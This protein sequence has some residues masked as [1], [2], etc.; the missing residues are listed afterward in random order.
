[1]SIVVL[2]EVLDSS[3]SKGT[4]RL[5]LVVLAEQAHEDGICWPGVDRLA[6]RVNTTPR[7]IQMLTRELEQ[8]GELLVEHSAGRGNT[9][10]YRVLPPTTLNRLLAELTVRLEKVKSS[11]EKVKDS[12]L[13]LELEKVKDRAEKAN[14]SSPFSDSEKVKDSAEKV[15]DSAQ[16]VKDSVK[17]V[18][19]AS[20]EPTRTLKNLQEPT[21]RQDKTASEEIEV[22]SSP[23]GGLEIFEPEVEGEKTHG[24]DRAEAAGAAG[25]EVPNPSQVK[26]QPPAGG[27]GEATGLEEVPAAGAGGAALAA[28]T[29][30]LAGMRLSVPDLI[31]EYPF[32]TLWTE[33]SPTR[34]RELTAEKQLEHGKRNYRGALIDA[35]D[36]EVRALHAQRKQTH[37]AQASPEPIPDDEIDMDALIRSAPLNGYGHRRKP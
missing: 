21:D 11:A 27:N 36:D 19:S 16:K 7:N 31:A 2:N 17:K 33:L 9:N 14:A 12:A 26:N 23:S 32:R 3:R 22:G 24:A 4:A 34:I 28:L 18:K 5:L 35:L 6:A 13:F 30:A 29:G 15:K 25:P 1:M 20:P 10:R 37:Q 8:Q